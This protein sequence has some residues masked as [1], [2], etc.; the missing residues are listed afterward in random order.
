MKIFRHTEEN[1]ICK[2]RE[3]NYNNVSFNDSLWYA[4]WKTVTE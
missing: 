1:R 3:T 2:I 4:R